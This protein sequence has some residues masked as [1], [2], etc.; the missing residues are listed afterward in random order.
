MNVAHAGG[1]E[2]GSHAEVRGW[3]RKSELIPATTYSVDDGLSHSSQRLNCL[4]QSSR[5]PPPVP[6]YEG[7]AHLAIGT[8][9]YAEPSYGPWATV[10]SDAKFFVRYFAGYTWAWVNGIPQIRMSAC[11]ERLAAY[12]PLTAVTIEPSGAR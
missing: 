2:W 11:A 6:A 10:R 7:P 3:I 1:A 9:I 4:H 8:R 12:V 5:F